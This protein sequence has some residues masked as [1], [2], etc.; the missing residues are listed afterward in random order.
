MDKIYKNEI[1]TRKQIHI[2]SN[3]HATFVTRLYW[4]ILL[5]NDNKIQMSDFFKQIKVKNIRSDFLKIE[6]FW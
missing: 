3:R 6:N 4:F 5:T 2:L 1:L